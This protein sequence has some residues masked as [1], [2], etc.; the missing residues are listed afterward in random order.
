MYSPCNFH[1]FSVYLFCISALPVLSGMYFL[2]IG[3][4]VFAYF[5]CFW[6][7]GFVF[8]VY[9]F[10]VSDILSGFKS[11]PRALDARF[12]IYAKNA[13]D[14]AARDL[15]SVRWRPFPGGYVILFSVTDLCLQC[16][17]SV[18][19]LCLVCVWPVSC[20]CL[21]CVFCVSSL[22][23]VCLA[24]VFSVS[25]LCLTCVGEWSTDVSVSTSRM[26]K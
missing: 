22:C 25:Y 9:Y 15:D 2:C 17:F 12:G 19:S 18:S 20:L 26:P 8:S 24:C 11:L 1:V 13:V 14:F 21:A 7:C 23:L 4:V 5:C 10:C 16:V 6:R 3:C